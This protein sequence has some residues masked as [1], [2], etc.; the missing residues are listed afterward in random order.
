VLGPNDFINTTGSPVR[1]ISATG[2]LLRWQHPDAA[3]TIING[4]FFVPEDWTTFSATYLIM[5]ATATTGDVV[6]QSLIRNGPA[7][8]GGVA[9]TTNTA[10]IPSMS[11]SFAVAITTQWEIIGHVD[12]RGPFNAVAGAP[13]TY[14]FARHGGGVLDDYAGALD[15]LGIVLEKVT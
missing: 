14:T 13:Y 3:T 4:T 5:G 10:S 11:T 6:L 9:G 15:F 8:I 7:I 1:G 12:T 2:A